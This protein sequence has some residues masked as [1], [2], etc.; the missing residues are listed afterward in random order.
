MARARKCGLCGDGRLGGCGGLG[1]VLADADAWRDFGPVGGVIRPG[2]LAVRRAR[3]VPGGH[4][5]RGA[6]LRAVE[7]GRGEIA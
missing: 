3:G 6:G 1:E 4:A 5:A 7:R 2:G